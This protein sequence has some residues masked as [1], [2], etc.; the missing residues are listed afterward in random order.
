MTDKKEMLKKS[1]KNLEFGLGEH[2]DISYGELITKVTQL[3]P[4]I[5][6]DLLKFG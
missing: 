1:L 3:I 4:Y 2:T 6:R 5:E